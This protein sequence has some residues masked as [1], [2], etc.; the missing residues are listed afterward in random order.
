M[1]YFTSPDFLRVAVLGF[2]TS[3]HMTWRRLVNQLV[4]E[5]YLDEFFHVPQAQAYWLGKWSQ[6]DPKITTP[7]GL[8]YFS[9]AINSLR[10]AFSKDGIKP[11]IN[12]WR[13]TNIL[14]LYFLLVA[15][16]V[17]AA[18][19]R[20][21]VQHESILQREFSTIC[22]PLIFFFSGLYYT[23]IF[24]T[25]TVVL[26]HIFW[27][28]STN[29]EGVLRTCYQLLHVVAGL[30]SLSARQTN[31]FWVAVYLGGLQVIETIKSRVGAH[32]VH[33]PPISESYFEGSQILDVQRFWF[34]F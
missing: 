24:S 27:S 21:S 17:L 15:L 2:I 10:D 13:F 1:S 5:P 19:G 18:V 4:P 32:E 3:A 33:D 29:A 9:Y 23:D 8:Y 7:P 31:V 34:L 20:R 6:W 28:A 12:E 25:F 16:Y 14:L 26:A 22:F 11:S 30:I